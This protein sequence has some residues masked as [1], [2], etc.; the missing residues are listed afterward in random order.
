MSGGHWDYQDMR[1]S[2]GFEGL[3][4]LPTIL[5]ALEEAFHRIDLAESNDSSR[6]DEEKRVYDILLAL[7]E[8]LFK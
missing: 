1:L 4:K 2:E 3:K 5:D 7:G 6:S 8:E